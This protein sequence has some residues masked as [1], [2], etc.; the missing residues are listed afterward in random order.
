MSGSWRSRLAAVAALG[1]V[2]G[3]V[4]GGV[5][6]ASPA[7]PAIRGC[8]ASQLRMKVGEGS[9]AA[10]TFALALVYT[11]KGSACTLFGYAGVSF[12]TAHDAQIGAAATRDLNDHP[13]V[14]TLATGGHAESTVTYRD[15]G[16]SGNCGGKVRAA[17]FKVYPPND[18]GYRLATFGKKVCRHTENLNVRP[19]RAGAAIRY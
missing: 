10:G 18:T 16:I 1:L 6:Q 2:L 19:V 11:N 8:I 14:V 3:G 5:A 17:F 4:T 13:H 7:H 12:V 15:P 9:G